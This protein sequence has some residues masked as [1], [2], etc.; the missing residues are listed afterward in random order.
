MAAAFGL[1]FMA[2]R[3][4]QFSALKENIIPNSWHGKQ[5][6]EIP[7]LTVELKVCEDRKSFDPKGS[8]TALVHLQH[9]SRFSS[10][11]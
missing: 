1:A 10:E 3:K 9:V 4:L 11:F 6:Q 8:H 2:L 5:I 7:A